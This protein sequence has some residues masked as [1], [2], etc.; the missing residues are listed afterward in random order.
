MNGREEGD[1]EGVCVG[2]D[3]KFVGDFVD[4]GERKGEIFGVD[5]FELLG[6][7]LGIMLVEGGVVEFSPFDGFFDGVFDTVHFVVFGLCRF[8]FPFGKVVVNDPLHEFRLFGLIE[9][10]FAVGLAGTLA[11]VISED[12]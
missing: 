7:D 9:V 10:D 12:R 4:G 6:E 3:L 1:R 8:I 11:D 5:L 2:D